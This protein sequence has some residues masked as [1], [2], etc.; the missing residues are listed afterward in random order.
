MNEETQKLKLIAENA[1]YLYTIGSITRE[2]AKRDIMPYI[3]AINTK[4]KELAKKY[5]Q[6]AKLVSF[7]SYCR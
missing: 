3:N 6:K 2:E 7:N 4:A 5:N 1:R